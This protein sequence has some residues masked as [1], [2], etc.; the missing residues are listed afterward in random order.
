MNSIKTFADSFVAVVSKYTP[1]AGGLSEQYSRSNGA[2]TSA[3]DLTW[4]YVAVLTAF[5]ARS[6]TVP[7][8]WNA[9]GL[10]LPSS[11]SSPASNTNT[12]VSF[13]F[14][15]YAITKWGGMSPSIALNAN[16]YPT[17]SGKPPSDF[18]YTLLMK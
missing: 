16:N 2:Q 18:P 6:G 7:A 5:S 17:W 15:E 10:T 4:S 1:S 11:C 13:T 14:N 3:S 9:S 12:M 8:S